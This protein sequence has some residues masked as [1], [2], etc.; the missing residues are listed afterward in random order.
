MKEKE[1]ELWLSKGLNIIK[2]E[3]SEQILDDGGHFERSPMYHAL[4]LEDLL[5]LTNLSYVY[6]NH[7][8]SKQV[9]L[10]KQKAQKMKNF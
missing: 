8:S 5:D 4:L 1:P 2:N 7:I 10:W 3:L 6:F 9:E